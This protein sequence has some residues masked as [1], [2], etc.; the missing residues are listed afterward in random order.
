VRLLSRDEILRRIPHG[1]EA[2]LI[3]TARI[4]GQVAI[5]EL[6]L[7]GS[8]RYFAGHYPGRPMLPA[9]TLLEMF[10]QV[11]AVLTASLELERRPDMLVRVRSFRLLEPTVPPTLLR[12]AVAL[13]V[14]RDGVVF[15]QAWADSARARVATARLTVAGAGHAA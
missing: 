9:A 1:E 8:E 2:L 6:C 11:G 13:E 15:L 12:V 3:S 14:A 10:G 4:D 5:S 7:D